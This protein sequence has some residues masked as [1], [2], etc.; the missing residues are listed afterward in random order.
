MLLHSR[1]DSV[2]KRLSGAG[3][4]LTLK[5]K[6]FVLLQLDIPTAED[7]LNVAVSIEQLSNIDDISL[8]Y[9]FFFRPMFEVLENGW[10]AFQ[11][12]IEFA[13]Y[14]EV[15]EDWRLSYVNKDFSVCPSYPH[16]V[17]VPKTVDDDTVYKAAAFRR[18]CK[19][20]EKLINSV[21]GKGRRGY[22]VDTRAQT[23]AKMAQSKGAVS[24]LVV[25][26][27]SPIFEALVERE[28]VQAGHPFRFRCA[29]SAYAISKQRQE[30]PVFLLFMDCVWQT[31]WNGLYLR[32]LINQGPQEEAW[33]EIKRIREYD[34]ELSS[35]VSK[36]RRYTKVAQ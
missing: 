6:D 8:K 1:V 14:K 16:A 4:T 23:V 12:E 30:S 34:K 10:D 28:W 22:I 27:L 15:S 19:E 29:K 33:Q 9:P 20:D 36:L 7:C 21:L 24:D 32:G 13:R 2:E 3:G 5:C 18:R 31:L 11:P 35:K 26:T 17:I 25:P